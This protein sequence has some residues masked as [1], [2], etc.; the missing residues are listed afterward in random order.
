M[1]RQQKI[2]GSLTILGLAMF[3]SARA[4]L[5]LTFDS[6]IQGF[7]NTIWSAG[8]QAIQ[9]TNALGGWTLGN[10][11]GPNVDF[12]AL[13]LADEIDSMAASGNGRVAFDIYVDGSSFNPGVGVWYSLNLAANSGGAATWT[14]IEKL[15]GDAWHNADDAA[16]YL[17]HVDKSFDELGW[18]SGDGYYQLFW[19]ANSDGAQRV[20]FF[21]DNVAVFQVVPEPSTFVLA[22]LGAAAL[23]LVRRRK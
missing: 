10:G 8:N 20:N 11:G 9:P 12:G 17:T 2:I 6:D 19:G 14:Q 22:G 1:N 5:S 15:S 13:G 3:T 7:Q 16:Q 23:W 21:V 4:D 18:A